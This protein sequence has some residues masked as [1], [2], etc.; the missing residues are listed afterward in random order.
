MSVFQPN[1]MNN[2]SAQASK[3]KDYIILGIHHYD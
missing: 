1:N 3:P 2:Y